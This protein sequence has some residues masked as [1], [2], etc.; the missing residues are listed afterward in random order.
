M[1]TVQQAQTQQQAPP[2]T[3]EPDPELAAVA[4][5]L[6]L[7]KPDGTLDLDTAKRINERTQRVAQ[8][9]AQAAVA[10]LQQSAVQQQAQNMLQRA[11]VTKGKSGQQPDPAILKDIWNRLDPRLTATE[12]G[13][14][15]AWVAAMGRTV[16]LSEAAPVKA[17]DDIPAPLL[18]ERAGGRDVVTGPALS[19]MEKRA[20]KSMGM[21]EKEYLEADKRPWRR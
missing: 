15:E 20:L 21:T 11:M 19:D 6:A 3:Q 16:A 8:Q 14:R 12:D 5:D 18:T 17:K 4:R 10:P 1:E 9:A 13:A 7:Y 2:Q